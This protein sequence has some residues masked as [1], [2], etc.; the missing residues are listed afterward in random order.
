MDTPEKSAKVINAEIIAI[1]RREI[2]VDRRIEDRRTE[3]SIPL[4]VYVKHT[5]ELYFSQLNGHDPVGLYAM[6][7]GEVEKS[8]LEAALEHSGFN[9]T[10]AAKALGMSRSTLRKKMDQY[11]IF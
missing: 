6:V 3:I 7:M 5:V 8:L 9:Q 11:R 2:N 10:K 4:P 1:E